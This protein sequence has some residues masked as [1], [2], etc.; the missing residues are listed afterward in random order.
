[1]TKKKDLKKQSKLDFRFMSFF[2]RIRDIFNPPSNK[3][4]KANIKSGDFVLDY[5]CGPGSYTLAAVNVVGP[6]GKVIAVDLNPLAINKVKEKATHKGLENIS[7]IITDCNTGLDTES[8]DVIICYDV[9]HGIDDKDCI[10]TEFS[11]VLKEK[12]RLSFDDHH[13]KETEIISLITDN[14]LFE[15]EEKNGKIYNFKKIS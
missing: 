8:I 14:G 10:L 15:F 12:S 5:G 11:R 13:L 6:S 9:L 3:I 4:E 7:T 1:M 2:F